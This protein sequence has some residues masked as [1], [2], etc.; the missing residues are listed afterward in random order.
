MSGIRPKNVQHA[1]FHIPLISIGAT[2]NTFKYAKDVIYKQFDHIGQDETDYFLP[3]GHTYIDPDSTITPLM[4]KAP[5]LRTFTE[6]AT[7][8]TNHK[9]ETE[10]GGEQ[11]YSNFTEK[12]IT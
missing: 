5:S 12:K 1:S 10:A 9:F 3:M 7:G 4:T 6:Y 11:T 2:E 8:L